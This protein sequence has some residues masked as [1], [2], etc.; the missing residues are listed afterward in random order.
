MMLSTTQK[1]SSK[2]L[3]YAIGLYRH[4]H[5]N[6]ELSFN[7]VNTSNRI[8]D[9]LQSIGITVYKGVGGTGVIAMIEGEQPGA[10]IALRAEL[11]ALPIS[12]QTGLDFASVNPNV[13]HACGH[14]MHMANLVATA[15]V[16]WQLKSAIK[17]RVM[18]I[19]QPGEELLPGGA[20]LIIDSE[21]F[22]SNKPD[23]MIG[24]HIL[25]ELPLGI[26][27]FKPGDYMASGDEIYLTVNGKGGHAA[28]PH[29]LVDPVLI[30]SH[31]I[32]ALQQVVSR[33]GSSQVPTVLSF[34]KIKGEGATNVIP[35]E[36]SIEGTFRTMDEQWR[37]KAHASIEQIAKGVAQSMGGDC[38]VDIRKGYPLLHNSEGLTERAI[39]IAKQYLGDDKVIDLPTRMTTDDFAYYAQIIPS[40]YFRLGVG[41]EEL[42][43]NSLHSP[44]LRVDEK[45]LEHSI[46]L[47]AW[48]TINLLNSF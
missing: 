16:L 27:G 36:V 45:I 10:T 20:N 23:L 47:S 18:L 6:P 25:P 37:R 2:E 44:T 9:E 3:E 41:G 30:A 46:G 5:K 1:Y 38:E 17:G 31:I 8:A 12:E 14:D 34:G 29:L 22:K 28:L 48:L 11:D 19:F 24:W 13:M 7:E 40:V 42:T 43:N 15:K 33:K 21:V 4:L 26:A 39:G 32:V 35:N